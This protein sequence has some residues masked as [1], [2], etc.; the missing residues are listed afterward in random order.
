MQQHGDVWEATITIPQSAKI[1]SYIVTEDSLTDT[2]NDSTYT[3]YVFNPNGKPVR[4]AGI[5]MAEL[6]KFAKYPIEAQLADIKRELEDYP[7]NFSAYYFYWRL[8]LLASEY[9]KGTVVAI[10][11]EIINLVENHRNNPEACN[12]AVKLLKTGIL[13]T[14]RLFEFALTIPRENLSSEMQTFLTTEKAKRGFEERYEALFNKPAPEFTLTALDSST[15]SLS[16]FRGKVVTLLFWTIWGDSLRWS[17]PLLDTI[18][19]LYETFREKGLSV[20]APY[21]ESTGLPILSLTPS[22]KSVSEERLR[23]VREIIANLHYSFPILC[24]SDEV[25]KQ[26]AVQHGSDIVLI[27]KKGIFRFRYSFFYPNIANT[28]RGKITQLLN[29]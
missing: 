2:N 26:Y 14:K 3:L 13:K 15:I 20:L 10:E 8:R 21:C 27:D 7:A 11:D 19:V 18:E 17:L 12:I 6:K 25:C 23:K 29:E 24:C 16:Q 4:D 28:L 5:F 1:L 9:D 22:P